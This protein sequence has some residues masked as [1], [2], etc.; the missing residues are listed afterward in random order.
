MR[1]D[2]LLDEIEPLTYRARCERLA[3]A[4]G[5]SGACGA[6]RRLGS[7]WPLR[8]HRTTARR[9]LG[10]RTAPRNNRPNGP[11][12]EKSPDGRPE[13]TQRNGRLRPERLKREYQT[14]NRKLTR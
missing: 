14:L 7:A 13:L 12:G 4:G 3:N 5:R 6:S 1:A 9:G 8:R 11:Q 10:T 2:E